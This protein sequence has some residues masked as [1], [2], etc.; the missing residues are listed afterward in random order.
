[1][2]RVVVMLDV[3][4]GTSSTLAHDLAKLVHE[5]NYLGTGYGVIAT[6]KSAVHLQAEF[7][8]VPPCQQY[9]QVVPSLARGRPWQCETYARLVQIKD[10]LEELD[11]GY[12][13]VIVT[14]Q[15]LL[16][17]VIQQGWKLG[18]ELEPPDHSLPHFCGDA[19]NCW[20]HRS[21]LAWW[22]HEALCLPVWWLTGQY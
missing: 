20:W 5:R 1:M 10:R 22:V 14:A 16:H 15:E 8:K 12:K 13:A 9:L 21:A 6:L 4:T 18:L 17:R 7:G 2:L 3:D 19:T 11:W